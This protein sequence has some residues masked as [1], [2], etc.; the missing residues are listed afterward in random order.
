MVKNSDFK[1]LVVDDIEMN[2]DLLSRRLQ[3]QGYQVQ[4]AEDG[5]RALEV[6]EAGNID[7]IMLDIM[8][9]GIT[10]IEVLKQLRES[11]SPSALPIIMATAKNEN[12]DMIEALGLGANDYVTK[13]MNWPVALA[14]IEMQL[15]MKVSVATPH[16]PSVEPTQ[17]DLEEIKPGTVLAE[18]Y[19]LEEEI[20]RG[21]YG[22]VYKAHHLGLNHAVAVKIL[23]QS[24]ASSPEEIANFQ[25][26]GINTCRVQHPHAVSLF[27]FG[28]TPQGTA[29][30]VMELL[31][32][33]TL[34]D[35][36][37][38]GRTIEPKRARKILVDVC[39]VLAAAHAA[40]IVHRDLKPHNILL[41]QSAGGEI[42][43]VLDFG[44]AKLVDRVDDS[45]Q[46]DESS[47]YG[48][49]YYI[50]PERIRKKPYDGQS[51]VYSV[52]ILAYEMLTGK[53]PFDSE[54]DD[55][56]P[57]FRMHILTVPKPPRKLNPAISRR[58]QRAILEA[59][60]KAPEDRPDAT[61][62]ARLIEQ[63]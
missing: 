37:S 33:H 53:L 26:E 42:V 32:G 35:E 63:A 39:E 19:R 8:M 44:I 20:G 45:T 40:G 52:G 7:L 1:I 23:Q 24:I 47:F 55:L 12:E 54:G 18:R 38:G 22:T 43:K 15:R 21:A 59:M 3:R 10:G 57:L 27:D 9:P 56:I 60:A 61:K 13:P 51:D 62:L 36:I 11:Y 30:L 46:D 16:A 6:V 34:Y 41:H 17:D 58:L 29:F 50:A 49:P 25:R 5:Y 31:D 2:R 14:R 28:V 48:T 4:E